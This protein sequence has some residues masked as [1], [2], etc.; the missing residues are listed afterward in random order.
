MVPAAGSGERLGAGQPKALV[1]VAGVAMVTRAVDGLWA[2]GVVDDVIVVAPAEHLEAMAGVVPTTARVVPGGL[3]RVAS[4]AAGLREIGDAD[5]VLVHDAARCLCPPEVVRAVAKAVG[6]G[7]VAVVPAIPVTDTVR[8]A[9][10]KGR[11]V[12]VD[13]TGL[14]AVQTPQGFDPAVLRR[15]HEAAGDNR[16]TD[17]AGLVEAI[18]AEV[19]TVPGDPR[20][21]K[22]TSPLDLAMADALARLS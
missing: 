22:V 7:H 6:D 21:F 14:L 5:V 8:R 9:D 13:R 4:V 15:A 11:V 18:G 19:V 20:A 16:A 3:D 12:L 10:A 1:E 2:S 17:D